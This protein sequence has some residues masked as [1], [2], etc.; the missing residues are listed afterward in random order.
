MFYVAHPRIPVDTLSSEQADLSLNKM[1]ESRV[2]IT[3]RVR[4][5]LDHLLKQYVHSQVRYK[6]AGD[7]SAIVARN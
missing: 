7:W 4:S 2:L 6:Y 3:V 5:L 1:I